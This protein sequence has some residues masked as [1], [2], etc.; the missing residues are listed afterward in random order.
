MFFSIMLI[1]GC[2][3]TVDTPLVE[4]DASSDFMTY[5]LVYPAIDSVVKTQ[6]IDCAYMQTREQEVSFNSTGKYVDK[7]YVKKGDTVK[8]GDLL[9]ELSSSALEEEIETL[10]YKVTRNEL[11]LSYLDTNEELA[12]QDAWIPAVG[13]PNIDKSD[14]EKSVKEIKKDYARRRELL[15]DSLEFDRLELDS[16]QSELKSSRLYASM[17]GIVY[18]IENKLEGSTTKAD[19]VIMT[20]VDNTDCLFTVSGSEYKDYFTEGQKVNMKISYTQASGDYILEPLNI[21]KWD[22]ELVFSLYDGPEEAQLEVGIKGVITIETA[23]KD[24]V[25]A[26]TKMILHEI[27]GQY[28]VYVLNDSNM[29]EIRYIEIGL[30]GDD[31]V[32]ILSGLTEGDKVIKK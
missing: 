32:E 7:V 24:N 6:R 9:C 12:I 18:S 5:S 11:L 20:I 2:G 10:T 27:E 30:I 17:D 8:K 1:S 13:N 16:K 14:I 15:N 4:V 23:R 21:D 26:I 22:D 31:N 25:L 28:Y 3:K 19:E 29:R